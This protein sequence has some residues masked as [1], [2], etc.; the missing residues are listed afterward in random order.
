VAHPDS[1]LN[2]SRGVGLLA[3]RQGN[4]PRALQVLERA[5]GI[6]READVSNILL[7]IG[8]GLGATYTL[9]GRVAAAVPLLTQAL[10]Q[11]LAQDI[12]ENL[13]FCRLALGEAHLLAGHPE[14]AHA[15]AEQAW[16]F[17]QAHQE[18]G[19]EAYALRFLGDLVAQ[20]APREWGHASDY[21]HQALT[22]ADALGMRPLQAHCHR[23]LGTLYAATGQTEQARAA[24]STAVE[25]Y[26]TMEM[27]FWL[28]QVEAVLAQMAAR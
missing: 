10:G 6:G 11:I 16:A 19:H 2:A 3:L 28:P 18:R 5:M 4:V 15:L 24:L 20:R 26:R 8:P 17:A 1:L 22:L 27:T 7:N 13:V 12:S 21:Y 14:E 25:L 9:A 23:S